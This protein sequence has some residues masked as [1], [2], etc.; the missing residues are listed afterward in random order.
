MS[1]E[2][3]LLSYQDSKMLGQCLDNRAKRIL[4]YPACGK[5]HAG[6]MVDIEVSVESANVLIPMKA[7]V[8]ARRTRS[9]GVSN[10]KGVYLEVIKQDAMRYQRLCELAD[11]EWTPSKKR[12]FPRLR[13][14][15]PA[16]YLLS[17]HRYRGK[18]FDISAQGMFIRTNRPLPEIGQRMML[19]L[20]TSRFWFPIRL[21]VEVRWLDLVD[22]RR[23]MGVICLAPKRSLKKLKALE[24]RLRKRLQL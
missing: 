13:I 22:D 17:K 3:I 6:Q 23:G 24:H 14:E 11:G 5:M 9:R 19:W 8:V 7:M 12:S 21:E 20:K 16:H 10:P 18:T 1:A 2:W 15:I 4:F